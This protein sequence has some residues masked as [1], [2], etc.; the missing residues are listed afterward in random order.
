MSPKIQAW[1][2]RDGSHQSRQVSLNETQT[3]LFVQVVSRNRD[4][5]LVKSEEKQTFQSSQ[6]IICEE[7]AAFIF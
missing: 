4:C 7:A 6:E 3:H 2:G 5:K 1:Y